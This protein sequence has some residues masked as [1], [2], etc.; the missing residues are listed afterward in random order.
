MSLALTRFVFSAVIQV[1]IVMDISP[2]IVLRPVLPVP[3]GVATSLLRT[4]W[5]LN[6]RHMI[7]NHVIVFTP[8]VKPLL[9]SLDRIGKK[10]KL[11]IQEQASSRILV[12]IRVFNV[13]HFIR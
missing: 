5:V 11:K 7:P 3:S 12:P 2:R 6:G 13:G 9:L 4:W 1:T 8:M 10:S